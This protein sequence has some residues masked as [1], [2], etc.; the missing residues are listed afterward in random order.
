M[1]GE[2]EA[3]YFLRSYHS[4]WDIYLKSFGLITSLFL[5]QADSNRPW[6]LIFTIC[7]SLNTG[8]GA[9]LT[10]VRTCSQAKIGTSPGLSLISNNDRFWSFRYV[11]VTVTRT[12][13]PMTMILRT[14]TELMK[15]RNGSL[16]TMRTMNGH[17]AASLI[18]QSGCP[19]MFVPLWYLQC[20]LLF[21]YRSLP[22]YNRGI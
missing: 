1:T 5:V 12:R 10:T 14:T 6:Y 3:V 13:K 9:Q 16:G 7:G 18:L 11:V 22:T 19:F 17:L 21:I 20:M 15:M 8:T 4:C 2:L